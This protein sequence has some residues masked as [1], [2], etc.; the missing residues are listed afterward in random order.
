MIASTLFL[1]LMS[2]T[3]IMREIANH[4]EELLANSAENTSDVMNANVDYAQKSS[5]NS[6]IHS[7]A[8][9]TE[10][11]SYQDFLTWYKIKDMKKEKNHYI[12]S[13]FVINDYTDTVVDSRF[14]ISTVADFYDQDIIR[15]LTRR[16][17]TSQQFVV[18]RMVDTTYIHPVKA[19]L[20]SVI[21]PYES[22]ESI[23]TFIVNFNSDALL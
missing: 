12:D 22:G 11:N 1:Y 16:K 21:I 5:I 14:G 9:Q 23:S 7:Y 18:S 10:S 4:S 17:T 20:I 15:M 3:I 6:A 8:L 13:I 19:R 2:S